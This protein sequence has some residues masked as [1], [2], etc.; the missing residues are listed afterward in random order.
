MYGCGVAP[1]KNGLPY[2]ALSTRRAMAEAQ[3]VRWQVAVRIRLAHL[4]RCSLSGR[5]L[6]PSKLEVFP[7]IAIVPVI[8]WLRS[9]KPIAG[10]FFGTFLFAAALAA[11][12]FL[13]VIC[14]WYQGMLA[15]SVSLRR[16]PRCHSADDSNTKAQEHK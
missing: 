15:S 2:R 3:G 4:Q 9:Y 16:L 12:A 11:G 6:L 1:K 7:V 8:V 13:Y 14:R 10:C 5:F